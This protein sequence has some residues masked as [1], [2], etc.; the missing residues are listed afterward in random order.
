MLSGNVLS[1]SEV[2]TQAKPNPFYSFF[3]KNFFKVP[4]T[5]PYTLLS[6]VEVRTSDSLLLRLRLCLL[7]QHWVAQHLRLLL[8]LL[9]LLLLMLL[10]D[11]LLDQRRLIVHSDAAIVL[12]PLLTVV[13]LAG[14]WVNARRLRGGRRGGGLLLLRLRLRLGLNHAE[15]LLRLLGGHTADRLLLLHG[16]RLEELLLL[17]NERGDLLSGSGIGELLGL[18]LTVV[19]CPNGLIVGLI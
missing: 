15:R 11:L 7:A 2:R 1:L 12:D 5:N 14:L 18:L 4:L 3:L 19:L 17:G 16:L 9:L 10:L 6:T 13:R 8:Q